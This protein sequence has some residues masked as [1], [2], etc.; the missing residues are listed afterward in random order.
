MTSKLYNRSRLFLRAQIIQSIRTFF[1][2]RGY[3]E[4]ETPVIIPAPA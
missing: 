1:I 3:L 2:S 4:V